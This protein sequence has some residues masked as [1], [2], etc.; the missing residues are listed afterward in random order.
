[1]LFA[2]EPISNY[3]MNKKI[4]TLFLLG[5]LGSTTF[6]MDQTTVRNKLNGLAQ[7]KAKEGGGET[8]G[9]GGDDGGDGG[10]G[11]DGGSGGSEGGNG[12]NGKE[13]CVTPPEV[14]TPPS[15]GAECACEFSGNLPGLGAGVA[16]GYEQRSEVRQGQYLA[17]TPDTAFTKICQSESC[18]CGSGQHQEASSGSKTRKFVIS[19]S[20]DIEES[21]SFSESG[22][23][24]DSQSSKYEK[25]TVC[26]TNNQN[27]GLG[28]AQECLSVQVC[29][30][31]GSGS[32][33]GEAGSGALGLGN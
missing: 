23:H 11:T 1:M 5:V 32:G 15:G 31:G 29:P 30:N 7:L 14:V 10:E 28:Q 3:K 20:I 25:N 33:S 4:I 8:G 16:Q 21:I 26:Q 17:S 12:G 22:S 9:N 27:G 13:V 6:A 2:L 18:E 19:G 24:S